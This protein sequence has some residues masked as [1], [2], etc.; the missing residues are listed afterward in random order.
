[1]GAEAVLE[2]GV[3]EGPGSAGMVAGGHNLIVFDSENW[4]SGVNMFTFENETGLNYVYHGSGIAP[5]KYSPSEHK[6]RT[7]ADL[8]DV[9]LDINGVVVADG[10]IYSTVT[11]AD[12]ANEDLT[13]VGGGANII[14]SEGTGTVCLN[15]GAGAD[16]LIYMYD[17]SKDGAFKNSDEYDSELAATLYYLIPL[18]S[19]QLKN[20]NSS[21]L[22]TTGAEPGAYYTYCT[23]HDH[24]IVGDECKMVEITWMVNGDPIISEVAYGSV[25]TCPITPD[26]ALDNN[27]HY[28]FAGWATTEDGAVIDLPAAETA[29][30]YY[31]VFTAE[32]HTY[33]TTATNGKHYCSCGKP[34]SCV[35]ADNDGDHLCDLGCG[36]TKSEHKYDNDDDADC[37]EC[38]E[39]RDV[40][41]KPGEDIR[42]GDANG[43]GEISTLD[44]VLLQQYVSGNA[45]D[46]N[47]TTSDANCDGEISTLDI[48]LLQQYVSGNDVELGPKK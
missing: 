4:T 15:N 17:Q 12:I 37:N 18:A 3:S 6:V 8:K 7:T 13:I 48:V 40:P 31:A 16:L 43:D 35:D 14:S 30:T 21:L 5:I 23:K 47:D 33:G 36:V 22:D 2:I 39:I 29:A 24:W 44:I 11:W 19:V 27:N 1:M 28:V 45:V 34:A 32:A 38:G 46:L 20:G 25:P 41:E 10:F 26:K 42:Y 9:V